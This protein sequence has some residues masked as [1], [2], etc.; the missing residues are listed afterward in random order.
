MDP[1]SLPYEARCS[2]SSMPV[3]AL[4]VER[5]SECSIVTVRPASVVLTTTEC[6]AARKCALEIAN[7]ADVLLLPPRRTGRAG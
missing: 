5:R 3:S 7:D 2:E 6:R 1:H 4:G